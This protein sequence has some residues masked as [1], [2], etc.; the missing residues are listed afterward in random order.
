[1]QHEQCFNVLQSQLPKRFSLEHFKRAV[2]MTLRLEIEDFH[3]PTAS[4]A[5][6]KKRKEN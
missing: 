6:N 5:M 2:E 4:T 3:I 1:M